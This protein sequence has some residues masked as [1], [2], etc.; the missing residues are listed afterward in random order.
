MA[1]LTSNRKSINN[2]KDNMPSDSKKEEATMDRGNHRGKSSS[3]KLT[4][5]NLNYYLNL[6]ERHILI[7]IVL[8]GLSTRFYNIDKPA[9]VCWDETHF[10]KMASWYI[11]R[12]FF[13]DVHPPL[14]KMLIALSGYATGYNG[15]FS[16][17][18]PG[19]AYTD[20]SQYL[21]M[22]IFCATLG[23]M[24]IPFT[25]YSTKS[26]TRSV[27][28]ATMAAFLLVF[29]NGMITLNRYILLDPP[30]LFFISG[31]I[32]GM[33]KFSFE[34]SKS[35]DLTKSDDRQRRHTFTFKWFFWLFWTGTFL[36]CAISVKFVGLFIVLLVGFRT[37]YELWIILGEVD[38]PMINFFWHLSIRSLSLIVWPIL[39]YMLIFWTHLNLLN[40][41]GN[42]DGFYS[43]AF[44]SQL[45]GNSLYNAT[46]PAHLAYGA[47]V[48]IK[49]N[50]IGGAYLHSHWHLYP[51]GIGARQQ[52]VTSYSHKDTNNRW[53]IKKS[54]GQLSE[55]GDVEYV[56]NGDLIRLEHLMTHRNL[57]SHK[58][59]APITKRHYQVTCYG[60]NGLG[61]A[62]DI[63]RIEVDESSLLTKTISST[64]ATHGNNRSD[65]NNQLIYTVRTRFRLVHVLTNCA[66]HSH[67]KQLPKWAYEQL[68]VTCNPRLYDKNNLWNIEDNIYASLPNVSF[69]E[70][71]PT[72]LERLFESH[73]VM[74]QGNAGL[75][76]KEGEVTSRPWQWPIN[77]RGQFFS[78]SNGQ[79]IYLLG[80]P[81][82]WWLNLITIPISLVLIITLT[83][84]DKRLSAFQSISNDE[85]KKLNTKKK[86]VKQSKQFD[87]QQQSN[88]DKRYKEASSWMLL[89][90]AL[91]YLPF[92]F[93]GR[94]L[95]FHH[96]FPA[97]IFSCMLTATTYDYIIN[98]V[99]IRKVK[100]LSFVT[101]DRRLLELT[102]LISTIVI[103]IFTFA[104]FLPITYGTKKQ[105]NATNEIR[106]SAWKEELALSSLKWLDSWEF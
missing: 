41:S 59:M 106:Q 29:D 82:I 45:I 8:L 75:K 49:N 95:Y 84:R 3:G 86:D 32:L 54:H 64:K 74:L 50:R 14:G 79:K 42:G 67:S 44:Q 88:I 68:E 12:T 25:Y 85:G 35:D 47:V 80:N 78:A 55:N 60:E 39:C 27:P 10:G 31:S 38:K 69:E 26:I 52:Q 57:H 65:N 96:Y 56:K 2:K 43:S 19:D 18:K 36:A 53:I 93:M 7:A 76:P 46:W 72:F 30:L 15:S 37:I 99:L 81:A 102:L 62:N 61:D 22:R 21:G 5:L 71:A 70:Y 87:E 66:L 28:A 101:S 98:H 24:I 103:H 11:N 100:C 91:H 17:S 16:Y 34:L 6:N 13:F 20:Y 83:I 104:L 1:T 97:F 90:W 105:E 48:T 9:H 94:I 51:E 73:S 4:F 89:G 23:F 40:R 77:Y 92:Y 33:S 58:E 63:W